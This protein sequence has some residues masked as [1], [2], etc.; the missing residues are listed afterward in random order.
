M[1]S[2]MIIDRHR[3]WQRLYSTVLYYCYVSR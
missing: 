3:C 1:D 2:L